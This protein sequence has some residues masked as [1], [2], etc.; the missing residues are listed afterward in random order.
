MTKRFQNKRV[1]L[2][3]AA[4]FMGPAVSELM[5]EE[6]AHVLADR[7]DLTVP[8]GV[9]SLVLEAGH[10]D[11]LIANLAAS[12]TMA[13]AHEATESDFNDM[14]ER[15]ALP[16]HRLVRTV[17]PQMIERRKGKIVVVGSA[18]ALRGTP[19]L[20]R[21]WIS[22]DSS[23]QNPLPKSTRK[24]IGIRDVECSQHVPSYPAVL[25]KSSADPVDRTPGDGLVHRLT[26][27]VPWCSLRGSS[28]A[29]RPRHG[30]R[31]EAG[32]AR[33][34]GRLCSSLPPRCA[35]WL[36]HCQAGTGKQAL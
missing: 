18:L 8:N 1:L 29:R 13:Y 23:L 22:A 36:R 3:D 17:L 35:P 31:A 14:F 15:L 10:I 7:R 25:N 27:S 4:G 34:S 33:G 28:G 16:L 12:Y 6:G 24:A 21:S 19:M 32:V 2:T 26:R 20:A 5:R 30:A 11:I 9:E